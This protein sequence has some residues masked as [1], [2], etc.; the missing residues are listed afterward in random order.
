MTSSKPYH[1]LEQLLLLERGVVV[2]PKALKDGERFLLSVV[3]AA[4]DSAELPD[5]MSKKAR[6]IIDKHLANNTLVD[7]KLK[8][9]PSSWRVASTTLDA[10]DLPSRYLKQADLTKLK[11]LKLVADFTLF[12]ETGGEYYP[13]DNVVM[14]YFDS[15]ELSPAK[16]K[17]LVARPGF[18]GLFDDRVEEMLATLEHELKHSVQEL[19]LAPVDPKQNSDEGEYPLRPGEHDP[20]V[21]SAVRLF[22]QLSR[23]F[24]WNEQE[25]KKRV[26]VFLC[27]DLTDAQLKLDDEKLPQWELR[28]RYFIAARRADM[29][30]WKKA[31]KL[32]YQQ[33]A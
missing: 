11:K 27:D 29:T 17:K 24:G 4:V 9:S 16:L 19:A 20:Q 33:L 14:I 2:S 8:G 21:K 25:A 6:A 23:R 26:R 5:E 22:K 13:R 30:T 31:V 32:F 28:S 7:A 1:L 3:A 15:L 18:A 12:D 10:S